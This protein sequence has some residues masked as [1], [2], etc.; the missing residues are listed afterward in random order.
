MAIYDIDDNE[1]FPQDLDL[2]KG[3]LVEEQK[4][5][6]HHDAIV[7]DPEND[8]WEE[9]SEW[10]EYETIERYILYTEEELE[11][12]AKE[13]AD[14]ERQEEFIKNG[15]FRLDDTIENLEETN[16]TVEDIILLLAEMLGTDGEVEEEE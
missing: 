4:F 12:R 7:P 16:L 15:S 14:K 10:D 8:K 11:Q 9:A 1:L 2:E 13:K 6:R 3:Y 5:I